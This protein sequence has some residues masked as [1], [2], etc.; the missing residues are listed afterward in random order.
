MGRDPPWYP[1]WAIKRSNLGRDVSSLA[2]KGLRFLYKLFI[3]EWQ[4]NDLS[5]KK[6]FPYQSRL[7]LSAN[8]GKSP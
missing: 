3:L 8:N 4:N 5:I 1:P 2:A 7:P 6:V